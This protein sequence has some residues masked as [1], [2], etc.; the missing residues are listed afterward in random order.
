MGFCR[1]M[2]RYFFQICHMMDR[3]GT[4]WKS[5]YQLHHLIQFTQMILNLSARYMYVHLKLT[6][7]YYLLFYVFLL[8]FGIISICLLTSFDFIFYF[9]TQNERNINHLFL[10][11]CKNV[12]YTYDLRH[13]MILVVDMDFL[14][15]RQA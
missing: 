11:S 10:S 15:M 3:V 2:P 14:Y 12:W 4:N 8:S 7:I 13:Y 5:I 1:K 6:F 9:F